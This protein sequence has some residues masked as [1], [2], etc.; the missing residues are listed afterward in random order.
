MLNYPPKG[1]VQENIQI[2][3][4]HLGLIRKNKES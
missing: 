3:T 2:K 4:A 1:Q